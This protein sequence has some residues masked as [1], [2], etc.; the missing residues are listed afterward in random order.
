MLI[1]VFLAQLD[2]RTNLD[3]DNI[4]KQLLPNLIHEG[5]KSLDPVI[6]RQYKITY[7]TLCLKYYK[8]IK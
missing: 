6:Y 4:I 2:T 5:F 1:T 8:N 7:D 3:V